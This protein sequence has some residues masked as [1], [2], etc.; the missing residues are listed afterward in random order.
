MSHSQK[1]SSFNTQSIL[2]GTDL[3]TLVRNGTNVNVKFSDFQSS[4]GVTGTLNQVGNSLAIP[5][6]EKI[7]NANNIRNIENGP[8]ILASVSAEN[9]IN[10][11]CNFSQD[12]SGAQVIKSLTS[13][14][15]DFRSIVAGDGIIVSEGDDT[16]R[17][18][19]NAESSSSKTV[20]INDIDDFPTA[21]SGVITLAN[22][23]DYLVQSDISTSNRFVTGN[24]NVLRASASQVIKL[25]YTGTGDM[26]TGTDPNFELRGI[27]INCANGNLYNMTSPTFFG[28][29]QMVGCTIE[30]CNTGGTLNGNFLTRIFSV[31][32]SDIKTKGITFVGIHQNLIVDSGISRLNGGEFLDLG[33]AT[34]NAVTV[35]NYVVQSAT[36]SV[37]FIKGGVSSAN[38][39]VGGLGAV[40]NNRTFGTVIPLSGLSPDDALWNFS[41]NNTIA[42]TRPDG[43]LSMQGNATNTVIASAGVGVLVAGTWNIET[44]SQMT[45]T[46]AGRLTYDG[47]KDAKLPLTGSVTIEP[48]SGGSQSMGVQIAINGA[49]I[50]NS[51]RQSETASG[52]PVTIDV[53]WQDNIQPTDFVEV[54][55]S[56]QSG[57]TDVLVSS[58]TLRIN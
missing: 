48:I 7:G 41:L 50:A 37:V 38:I 18:D 17:I 51:L 58:A 28:I 42:D 11:K 23:T 47:G 55:V 2:D 24:S 54:F 44:M 56:N 4:L 31:A 49:A 43:L 53:H 19:F 14:R 5:V 34:F 3:F 36:P 52:S 27:T 8:G 46:A 35:T 12:E 15:Y 45:G 21:V 32:W 22:D 40:T 20:V 57:T 26:F 29:I 33:T 9:G 13:D 1:I 6:L 10:L 30:S 25:T 39:N 16:I